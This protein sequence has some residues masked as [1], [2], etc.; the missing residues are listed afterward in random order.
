MRENKERIKIAFKKL[1]SNVFFDKTTLPLRDEIVLFEDK[2]DEKLNVI[3]D[4]LFVGDNWEGFEREILDKV[5]V[6]SYPKSLIKLSSSTAIISSDVQE[7]TMD[8]PQFFIDLPVEGHILGVLWILTIGV[9]LDKNS[10]MSNSC[11]MYAHSY[12]NRLRKTLINED[13]GDITY[14]PYLF[15]PYFSQ[16]ESWRDYGLNRAKERLNDKQ[17][18]FILTLDFKSFF[19]SVDFPESIFDR[20]LS[21]ECPEWQKRLNKFV[22]HVINKYSKELNKVVADESFIK[23]R[24]VLPIGFLPSNILSNY[25]LTI[26]DNAIVSKWNP[27]YY[28]RYVDDIIIVDKVEQ[29]DDIYRE[30]RLKNGCLDVDYIIDR[31]LVEKNIFKAEPIPEENKE[32]STPCSNENNLKQSPNDRKGKETIYKI[33]SDFS[34]S[35]KAEITVQSKKVKMF[36]FQ[37]GSTLALLD[38][39]RTQI[40]QNASE[41]KLFPQMDSVLEYHNY[42]EIF[43]LDNKEGIN[44]FRGITGI[45]LDKYA[46]S[47]FLGKYR[48]V[49][50]MIESRKENAFERDLMLIMDARTLIGNYST[51]ERIFEILVVNER[52]DLFKKIAYRILD[53]IHKYD[54]PDSIC[55]EGF[56]THDALF[57]FFCS[58]FSRVSAI[59]W[60]DQMNKVISAISKKVNQFRDDNRFHQERIIRFSDETYI[61][62]LRISYCKTRMINKYLLPLPIDCVIGT[63]GEENI[64][65]CSFRDVFGKMATDPFKNKRS[66][67]YVYYPYMVSPNELSFVFTCS[68]IKQGKGD[69]N[70]E[71]HQN[72]V[73]KQFKHLNYNLIDVE[74][75][76]LSLS[77]VKSSSFLPTHTRS[78]VSTQKQNRTLYFTAVDC[79]EQNVKESLCVAVGNVK[80]NK[81]YFHSALDERPNRE[82]ERYNEFAKVLDD[83]AQFRN[84]R[85]K[86]V[87]LLVLP[88]NYLPFE[89]VPD[90]ARFCA[91]NHIALVSGIEHLIVDPSSA[92]G[93]L[94]KTVY[95]LTVTI[96]PYEF[97]GNQFANISFHNK[98]EL[99]PEEK[100]AIVGRRFKINP[101]NSYQ[102]FGWHNVWFPVYCCYELASISDRSIFREYA[103]FIVAVEWNKDVTYFSNIVESLSRDLHC[104]CIQANSSEYGDSRIVTPRETKYKDL[105]KTKGGENSFVIIGTVDIKSLRDFQMLDYELQVDNGKFK[106][107]PPGIDPNNIIDK[108]RKNKLLESFL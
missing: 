107:T 71:K 61:R 79:G 56:T 85:G 59:I 23:E 75:D 90:V 74:N 48:K 44:K 46:L 29:N 43:T 87:D 37:S 17:D 41:F 1:K 100:R 38:T 22:F 5:G 102:L 45:E 8:K 65:L 47:K 14:S 57:R 6:F 42:C 73:N 67:Q 76:T 32:K 34:I 101:G 96:L 94:N 98:V 36:Y 91:K 21:E 20:F 18:A 78:V 3:Y 30:A 92:S 86:K 4:S 95:N 84:K 49:S 31:F 25:A 70:P 68:K 10:D 81:E 58:A 28:G 54:V 35:E 39:F 72:E 63:I 62:E 2:L 80:L 64:V 53:A 33:T 104:Y 77:M 82:Y 103:D 97:D 40:A 26:F 27:V 83:A 88:E 11:G 7:I 19:Y 16:Y 55:K 69:L 52:Y 12:G 9:Q 24:N 15:E 89:W 99:A 66:G 50:G 51:W 13:S 93:V 108:K 60:N 105:L 106:P